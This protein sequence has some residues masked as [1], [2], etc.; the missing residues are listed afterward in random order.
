MFLFLLLVFGLALYGAASLLSSLTG[1][2][3]ALPNASTPTA[4][5]QQVEQVPAAD[6]GVKQWL[7]DSAMSMAL[8]SAGLETTPLDDAGVGCSS[9]IMSPTQVE[10]LVFSLPEPQRGALAKVLVASSSVWTAQLYS[11]PR[12]TGLCLPN[13]G[14]LIVFPGL[15]NPLSP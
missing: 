6:A 13:Q 12:G 9:S 14:R 3:P 2:T 5:V 7:A 15:R 1:S 8:S 4:Q 10:S 11:G